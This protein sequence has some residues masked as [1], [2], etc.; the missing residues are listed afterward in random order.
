MTQKLPT[1]WRRNHD[2]ETLLNALIEIDETL[3]NAESEW[4]K[5]AV[6]KDAWRQARGTIEH[7]RQARG[8][9]GGLDVM[10]WYEL[11]R[12]SQILRQMVANACVACAD[13]GELQVDHIMPRSRGGGPELNNLQLLCSRCNSSKSDMTMD[14]W[15]MSDTPR[16]ALVRALRDVS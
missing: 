6:L 9:I 14:E 16:A 12:N 10:G 11:E 13:T 1:A 8:I 15:L 5:G 7:L 2:Y 3:K 4:H